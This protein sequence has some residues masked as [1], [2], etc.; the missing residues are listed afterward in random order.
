[1]RIAVDPDGEGGG[2]LAELAPSGLRG[3]VA[4]V[5]DL[6][7]AIAE[8]EAG[9]AEGV[10]WVWAD[11]SEAYPP[12]LGR[13]VQVGRCHDVGLVEALLLAHDG[14]LGEPHAL[15]AAW[16]RLHGREVPPD[17][18]RRT[19]HGGEE[20]QPALFAAESGTLPPG[21][22]RLAAL[23]EVHADQRKRISA[24]P[25]PGRFALLCAVE[26]AGALAAAE[27]R[28]TGIPWSAAAHDRLLTAQL[29]ARPP[30]GA[31]P[32][33]LAGLVEEVSA[34]LGREVNPDSPAQLIKA[35]AA[36]GHDVPST[37]SEVLKGV[38]HPA[39]RPLLRYKE[40]ARLHSAHGWAW[41]DAWV[42]SGRFR[43][44]YVVGGV[45]SGR[46]ATRGGGAL[47]IPKAV[48]GAIIADPGWRLV[49]ADAGQ[50]EPRILAAISRDAALARAAGA[51]DLYARLAG[52]FGGDRQRA[53]IGLLAAMYGQTGGDAA[54]L[55]GVLRRAYPRAIGFLDRA[56]EEGERGGL[57]RSWLG[58]TCPP[59]SPGWRNTVAEGGPGAGGA[60]R[61]RGRFTRNFT[62]QATAAEW[63]LVFMAAVRRGLAGMDA[64]DG[65]PEIVFFQHDELVM[66]VPA[67][68]AEETAALARRAADEAGRVMFG[69]GP[70]RFP[71]DVSV[72]DCYADA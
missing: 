8:H 4:E 6:A 41:L 35:F 26:S 25:D 53:K 27:M 16:A 51:D 61:S 42:R 36:A 60:A 12:L 32:A 20:E 23:A 65:R 69:E 68:L 57:V 49:S 18:V 29:G 38:D 2:R 3:A 14:R 24:L 15:G 43:P 56:A 9:A 37:R 21:A 7:D 46:W 10:R 40:L 39:V 30:G 54:P 45:V 62:V 66:H 67:R 50:L 48:R 70:V 47:Q 31:R 34:A 55:L 63:A 72:V 58:R 33:V 17:P 71:L 52:A 28:R 5:G 19:G 59:P 64:S 11:T 13:G 22:D 44:D 1:M